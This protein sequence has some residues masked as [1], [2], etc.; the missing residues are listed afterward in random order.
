MILLGTDDDDG[1]IPP[2]IEELVADSTDE[3]R[4]G[5]DI[6][7]LH[8]LAGQINPRSL[9]LM[10]TIRHHNVHVLIDSGRTHNFI[11]PS[12]VEFLGLSMQ[13]ISSFRVY[14]GNGDFLVSRFSCPEVP[15]MMQDQLFTMDFYVLPIEGPDV[16]G[17]QWI[18]MLGRVAH[19]YPALSM[20]FTWQDTL[21]RLQGDV[22]LL[23][24]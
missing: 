3:T 19:D 20:G 15:L 1:N 11:K 6:S 4:I 12:I 10:G 14:I 21:V 7:S 23:P 24:R 2:L 18:H 22:S 9:R 5:R 13:S 17:Y 16:L 8:A